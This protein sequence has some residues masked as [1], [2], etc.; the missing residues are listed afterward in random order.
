MSRN[1]QNGNNSTL[2]E[3]DLALIDYLQG[4]ARMT[5]AELGDLV[6]L[7][8]SGVQKRL[9]KLEEQGIVEQYATLIN[10]KAL[11]YDLLVFVQ[12][13]LKGHTAEAVQQFDEIVQ[14]MPEI[15]E[16]HR[17]TGSAD[18]LVKILVRDPEHLDDFLMNDL[19][20]LPAVERVHSHIVLKAIK[21]TTQ[22][23]VLD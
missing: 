9:R 22:I 23:N 20:R 5:N 7:S 12:I 13:I 17:I 19:M 15:L 21:E 16:C 14:S 18:Y 10:R 3:K 1:S 4:D 2:D 11:G 8:P 6:G